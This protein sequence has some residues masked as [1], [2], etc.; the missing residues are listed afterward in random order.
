MLF[1]SFL[2]LEKLLEQAVDVLH[3]HAGPCG[4]A[5]AT[6]AIDDAGADAAPAR[7]IESMMAI[8]RLSSRSACSPGIPAAARWQAALAA[9]P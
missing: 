1:M 9:C 7:V 6:R 4:D 2:H 5:A 8:W 3:L